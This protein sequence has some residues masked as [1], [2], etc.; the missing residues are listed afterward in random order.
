MT[1]IPQLTWLCRPCAAYDTSAQC[2]LCPNEGGALKKTQY[3]SRWV[4][5]SCA[6]WIPEVGIEN[7]EKMEPITK[8]EDILVSAH[9]NWVLIIKVFLDKEMEFGVLYLQEEARGLYSMFSEWA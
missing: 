2:V 7:I 5:V 6:L 3:G 4:H 1:S 9:Q 8:V